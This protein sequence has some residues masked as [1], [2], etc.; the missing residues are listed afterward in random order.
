M[1]LD[2]PSNFKLGGIGGNSRRRAYR[3]DSSRRG[4]AGEPRVV[5]ERRLGTTSSRRAETRNRERSTRGDEKPR[6]VDK[7]RRETASGVRREE[8]RNRERGP[9]RGGEK[10]RAGSDERRRETASGVRREGLDLPSNF[11][12]G[13]IGGNSRRRAY[14]FDS[15]RRGRA[16]EPRVVDERRLGTTS[17]RRAETRNR[18]RSTRGD[19]KPRAGS[20]ERRRETASGVRREEA[21]NRERGPTRGD[22]KSRAG[23]TRGDEKPRAGSDERRRGTASG[24]RREEARNRERGP[25][26]GGEE[27]RAVHPTMISDWKQELVKRAG[28]L[29]ARGNRAP[30]VGDAQKVIDDLHR[31]IGQLQVEHRQRRRHWPPDAMARRCREFVDSRLR[32]S[33]PDRASAVPHGQAGENAM[34]FPRLAHRSAAAHKLHSTPQQDRMNLISGKGETSS[35]LPRRYHVDR[36]YDADEIDNAPFYL[37]KETTLDLIQ[38]V[39][40]VTNAIA[41]QFVDQRRTGSTYGIAAFYPREKVRVAGDA[42]AYT[43]Q[44]DSGYPVTFYFCPHCGSTVYWVRHRRLERAPETPDLRRRLRRPPPFR[45]YGW[46]STGIDGFRTCQQVSNVISLRLR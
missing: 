19:E 38:N 20:D 32:R 37:T 40:A 28:E 23:S 34:R 14:Q 11:K 35:R 5:D 13:G 36:G 3:F 10:P 9:T 7:R 46:P 33:P 17:S 16:G 43:R 18:E 27:P 1:G 21:R 2:L 41:E 42:T 12:L 44:S 24:V 29:F 26:R 4:R 22:E 6:A 30:A 45:V 15:S 31:K 8:A 25:T 39:D